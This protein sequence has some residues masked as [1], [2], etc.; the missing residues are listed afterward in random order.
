MSTT[1]YDPVALTVVDNYLTSCC[2]DMG[3]TMMTTAY[4]PIFNESL[5]FSCVIF[6]PHGN[7]LNLPHLD[8][9]GGWL[10]FALPPAEMGIHPA[11]KNLTQPHAGQNLAAAAVY[12]MCDNL[13]ETLDSLSAKGGE[14]TLIQEARWG[15]A[16]SIR[17]PSGAQLG[18]YEPHHPLATS[19]PEARNQG[20]VSRHSGA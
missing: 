5:D 3:V 1:T 2:R 10:I 7:M 9:G 13:Q 19:L 4:S 11:E 8:A 15:I 6:D 20:Q 18:V 12:L 17:L 14:H 16:S